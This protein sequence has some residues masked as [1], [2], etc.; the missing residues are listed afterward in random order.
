MRASIFPG[1]ILRLPAADIPIDGISAYL[2]QGEHF[3]MVF[4][5]FEKDTIVPAHS[6]A[7]QWKLYWKV[8][9]T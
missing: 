6:H 7:E 3:Q 5:S 9:W 2:A 4:M 8:R 1:P